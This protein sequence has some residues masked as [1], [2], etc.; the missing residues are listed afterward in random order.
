MTSK[1]EWY[2]G[3]QVAIID[4]HGEVRCITKIFYC[5]PKS[6]GFYV[7]DTSGFYNKKTGL[8]KQGFKAE[9]YDPA[10]HKVSRRNELLPVVRSIAWH[11]LTADQL[12]RIIEIAKE[13]KVYGVE[14]KENANK[15]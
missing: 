14:V 12:E 6:P 3:Q 8:S 15:A 9:P 11:T 7:D 2:K 13:E 4:R 5:D 10:K 1:P